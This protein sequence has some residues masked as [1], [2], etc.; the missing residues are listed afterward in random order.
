MMNARTRNA[1]AST[2]SGIVSHQD[3]ARLRYIKYHRAA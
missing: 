2:A 1:P 3:T